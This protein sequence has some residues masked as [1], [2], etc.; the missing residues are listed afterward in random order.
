MKAK[1]YYKINEVSKLFNIG[2]DSL[3]YYEKKGIL[4]PYRDPDN[5]YRYYSLEDI[6]QL[7]FIKE[8][9]GLNFSLERIKKFLDNR[10]LSSTLE[11]LDEELNTVEKQISLLKQTK[12]HIKE[13]IS[14][15]TSAKKSANDKDLKIIHLPIRKCI[16]IKGSDI[17][18]TEIDFTI[19]NYLSE[20]NQEFNMIG[21]CDCY[22]LNINALG[23]NDSYYLIKDIFL[24][25]TSSHYK[26]NYILPEGDY[27]SITYKGDYLKTKQMVPIMLEYCKENNL[28]ICSDPIELCKIDDYETDYKYEYVTEIQIRVEKQ[29]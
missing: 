13:R 28:K 3:R 1:K 24:I 11:L 29:L 5:N 21:S 6:K 14:T 22:T 17:T 12:K 16:K 15:I 18:D 23:T 10:T 8:L 26:S 27:L 19:K 20:N 2:F 9:Q 4:K 25:C 7:S